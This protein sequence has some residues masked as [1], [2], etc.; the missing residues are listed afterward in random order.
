MTVQSNG[1]AFKVMEGF[2][3]NIVALKAVGEIA[4][5]DYEEVLIPLCEAAIKSHEKIRLLYWCG[6]DFKGFDAGAMLEDTW[7]GTRH[8]GDFERIAFVSDHAWLRNSVALF[9]SL[10]PAE[11]KVFKDA[12]IDEAKAWISER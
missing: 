12:S 6:P 9:A 5:V 1:R 10:M 8:L 11:I 2:T 7:F 4:K 3:S